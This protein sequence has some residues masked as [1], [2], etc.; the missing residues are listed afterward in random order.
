[1]AVYVYG[2]CWLLVGLGMPRYRN[3][4]VICHIEAVV[5][6]LIQTCKRIN[7][8]VKNIAH[9]YLQFLLLNENN[10]QKCALLESWHKGAVICISY[11]GIL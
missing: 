9:N 11:R 3:F 7:L 1:M 4:C 2:S 8:S 6:R 5:S 10:E